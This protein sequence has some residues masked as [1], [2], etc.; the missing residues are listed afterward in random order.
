MLNGKAIMEMDVK[1]MKRRNIAPK[2]EIMAVIGKPNG[3]NLNNGPI[4]KMVPE[5]Q[6]WS[7][8]NVAVDK[9]GMFFLDASS[10]LYKRVCLSVG[11]SIGP[12]VVSPSIT[13]FLK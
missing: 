9:V 10:R 8:L 2:K 7:A 1:N 4:M 13:H 3:E 11:W 12:L 6:L 5:H